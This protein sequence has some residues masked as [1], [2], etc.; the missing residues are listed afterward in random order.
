MKIRY[1]IIHLITLCTVFSFCTERKIQRYLAPGFVPTAEKA[2]YE[3]LNDAYASLN[4]NSEMLL[5]HNVKGLFHFHPDPKIN[6]I[7]EDVI[8]GLLAD[9]EKTTIPKQPPDISFLESCHKGPYTI[10][11]SI[12]SGSIEHTLDWY[13]DFLKG[14]L[15][16][17]CAAFYYNIDPKFYKAVHADAQDFSAFFQKNKDKIWQ[18]RYLNHQTE[19]VSFSGA[20]TDTGRVEFQ[21][22][23]GAIRKVHYSR[24]NVSGAIETYIYMKR[25]IS[26]NNYLISLHRNGY[27]SRPKLAFLGLQD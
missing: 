6:G 13:E 20:R 22:F 21:A 10:G 15:A 19:K 27:E 23:N 26:P 18:L 5:L 7:A 4:P 1:D 3:N 24:R 17:P 16:Y 8:I 11:D 12:L 25:K 14:K 2:A 9:R